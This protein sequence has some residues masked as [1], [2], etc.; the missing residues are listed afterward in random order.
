MSDVADSRYRE[1]LDVVERNL[2]AGVRLWIGADAFFFLGFVFAFFY[3]RALN[4]NGMFR[5]PHDQ[6]STAVGTA[7]LVA[8]VGCAILV[9]YGVTRLRSGDGAGWRRAA[10]IAL[11]LAVAAIV[12]QVVQYSQFGLDRKVYQ[13]YG[14]IFLGWTVAYVIHL[15]GAGAWLESLFAQSVRERDAAAPDPSV[16]PAAAACLA[17][18]E[19]MAVVGAIMYVLLY[20]V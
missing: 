10:A 7:V 15:V 19:F 12:L 6:Q 4:S 16:L 14:S 5:D 17:F 8:T 9:R 2:W 20:L 13:G 3:L 1:P 18:W 11:V